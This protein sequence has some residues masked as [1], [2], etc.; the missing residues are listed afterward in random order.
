MSNGPYSIGGAPWPGLSKLVEEAGEVLQVAG[1]LIGTGG[2]ENHWDGT[3]LRDRMHEEI[4][5][6][7]A[8][9]Q[10]VSDHN[11]LDATRIFARMQEKLALYEKWH[12]EPVPV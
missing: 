3:N 5:D 12:R 10:F 7:L 11:G 6:L 2:A 8:A 4:G 9:C 1:K